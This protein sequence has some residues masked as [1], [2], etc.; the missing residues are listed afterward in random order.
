M[1]FTVGFSSRSLSEV[2]RE[3]P[4]GQW[5]RGHT[6]TAGAT[7]SIPGGEVTHTF[8]CGQKRKT[9]R[10]MEEKSH[11]CGFFSSPMGLVQAFSRSCCVK[12]VLLVVWFYPARHAFVPFFCSFVSSALSSSPLVLPSVPQSKKKSSPIHY[13]EM[14]ISLKTPW[15][16]S[17]KLFCHWLTTSKMV[18]LDV[19]VMR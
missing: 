4:G 7:G 8:G 2:A 5:L 16:Q 18:F 11:L 10:R 9:Q 17:A 6:S 1:G 13:R 14:F 15:N 19:T 12:G 3:F